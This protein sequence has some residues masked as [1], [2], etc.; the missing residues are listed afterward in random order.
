MDLAHGLADARPSAGQVDDELGKT[1]VAKA[2]H[3]Q[4]PRPEEARASTHR[5]GPRV[6][7]P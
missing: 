3:R 4:P 1:A 5:Q 6:E 2:M 7:H